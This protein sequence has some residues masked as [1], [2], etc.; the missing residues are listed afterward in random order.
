M[1]T[2]KILSVILVAVILISAL[3]MLAGCNKGD[4]AATTAP[5]A[6]PTAAATAAA[7]DAEK[8][9][10]QNSSAQNSNAQDNNAQAQQDATS[11]DPNSIGITREEAI[12]NVKQQAGSGA[13][14][15][16]CVEGTSPEGFPC[17]VIV[18]SPITAS[19]EAKNVTYYSGYQFCYAE[20]AGADSG[21]GVGIDEQTAIA[22]VRQQAGTG[23]QIISCTEGTSPEGFPCYVIVVAPITA[24]E[25]AV[26]DTY[27][28]GYLFCY[29]ASSGDG[30]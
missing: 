26:Y 28:S 3:A 2:T 23:A 15:V 6:A 12:A 21:D 19:E 20:G 25:E 14:I 18:V 8:D 30:E 9:G 29:K 4:T 27:Y 5:T 16:S 13:Q 7:T 11:G 22:N 24:S 17:Y 1:K 10:A